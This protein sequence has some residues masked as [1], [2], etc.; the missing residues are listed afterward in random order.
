M[1]GTATAA[2]AAAIAGS[3]TTVE[4]TV[5]APSTE[6]APLPGTT[7]STPAAGVPVVPDKY[8]LKLPDN[9]PVDPALTERT[10]AIA[11]TLGLSNENAQKTLEFAAQEAARETGAALSAFSPPS[12]QNPEGGAKW[13]EQD[14]AWRAAALTDKELGDGKPEKLQASTDLAKKVLAKFGDAESIDFVDSALGS[15]PALLRVL[16]RIGRAMSESSLVKGAQDSPAQKRPEH[17]LYNPDGTPIQPQA[18]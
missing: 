17:R 9:S 7:V 2:D 3:G 15:N 18:A 10:A 4:T 6:S 13:R 5:T 1:E 11:R 16:V 12:D 14:A 8:V